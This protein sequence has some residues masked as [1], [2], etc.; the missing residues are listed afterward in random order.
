VTA[1]VCRRHSISEA[2]L[3]IAILK[4]ISSKNGEAGREA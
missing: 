4:D 1:E 2:M 3:D